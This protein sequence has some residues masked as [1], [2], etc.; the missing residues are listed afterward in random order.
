[1]AKKVYVKP[2]GKA[3]G[4][5]KDYA[6]GSK[7]R[8]NEYESRGWKQDDTTKGGAPRPAAAGT[9][10]STKTKTSTTTHTK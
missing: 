5:M 3:T 4:K 2:G 7:S 8:Y 10:T 6:I 1:M 9:E